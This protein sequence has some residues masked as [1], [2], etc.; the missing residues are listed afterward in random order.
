[1]RGDGETRRRLRLGIITDADPLFDDWEVRLFEQISARDTL[2]LAFVI[3]LPDPAPRPPR[4]AMLERILALESR[5]VKPGVVPRVGTSFT[6]LRDL[7]QYPPSA[8]RHKPAD[9]LLNHARQTLGEGLKLREREIWSYSHLMQAGAAPHGL[10]PVLADAPFTRV[11][12]HR[13][14]DG[15]P[16]SLLAEALTN[17]KAVGTYNTAF[18]EDIVP[19]LVMRELEA[20]RIG[21]D[22][23]AGEPGPKATY[24]SGA[25]LPD[26]CVE[27]SARGA[28][29]YAVPSGTERAREPAGG[30]PDAGIQPLAYASCLARRLGRAAV[31][32]GAKRLGTMPGRWSLMVGD[33]DIL[34]H[35]LAGLTEL[36]QPPGEHRADPFLLDHDG[37]TWVFFEAFGGTRPHGEIMVGRLEGNRLVDEQPLN[38][39]PI[40]VSYP[41]VFA[42]DGEIYMVPET[43]QRDRVEVWRCVE[44]PGRWVMHAHALTGT[45]PADSTLVEH[46]GA[47][48]LFTSHGSGALPDYCRELH[49]YKVNGPDLSGL[50]AHAR[51]P[52]LIDTTRARMGGRFFRRGNTLYRPGQNTSFG[53][54]GY[55]LSIMAIEVL[56]LSAYRERCVRTITPD[57]ARGTTG[58]HH[59]DAG[60]D[61]K[62][63]FIVDTRRAFGR[64]PFGA[65]PIALHAE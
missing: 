55:G 1:M 12:I 16:A 49:I 48:W 41:Q 63:R 26:T 46:D 62:G 25:V 10:G 58:C 9:I 14:I 44:F 6:A 50:T 15:A 20:L 33:G 53:L 22:A 32:R 5:M 39:G 52:V 60:A 37:D 54:Y 47:W 4:S 28:E 56:T 3:A 42:H 51:N 21:L 29:G 24:T 64:P 65:R 61:G 34:G 8:R 13:A 27:P 57:R 11:A 31:E 40:H 38:L 2:H 19:T 43:H 18:A 59:L 30:Q 17:T 23:A 36:V 45:A 7:V 35:D